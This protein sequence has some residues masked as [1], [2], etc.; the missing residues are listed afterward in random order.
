MRLSDPQ[1][2][3]GALAP[4]VDIWNTLVHEL[5]GHSAHDLTLKG[6]S[7]LTASEQQR[8][9]HVVGYLLEPALSATLHPTRPLEL[10]PAEADMADTIDLWRRRFH[11]D[12]S[13]KDAAEKIFAHV[14]RYEGNLI[15]FVATVW[16]AASTLIY[17]HRALQQGVLRDIPSI[18]LNATDQQMTCVGISRLVRAS[19]E[20]RLYLMPLMWQP[21]ELYG[22]HLRLTPSAHLESLHSDT[23]AKGIHAA[24]RATRKA[25]A[26]AQTA[27][28]YQQ[29]KYWSEAVIVN[30]WQT[31]WSTKRLAEAGPMKPLESLLGVTVGDLEISSL[32]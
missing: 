18:H 8:L 10:A 3:G 14:S 26:S 19:K 16:P 21:A 12:R 1:L 31:I 24:I 29:P 4:I 22:W 15:R 6:W 7:Q 2:A 9:E 28:K 30:V 17:M 23:N 27:F 25:T 5:A 20:S 11:A 13:V 32:G